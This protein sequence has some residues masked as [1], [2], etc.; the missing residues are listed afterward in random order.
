LVQIKA[1]FLQKR[2]WADYIRRVIIIVSIKA[3]KMEKRTEFAARKCEAT[4][5]SEL[6]STSQGPQNL[7]V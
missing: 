7:P 2:K 4:V 3:V 1:K 5:S 6:K